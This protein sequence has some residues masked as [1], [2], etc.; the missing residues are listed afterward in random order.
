MAD[1][2]RS[3]RA[4]GIRRPPPPFRVV[5]VAKLRSLTPYLMRATF[6]GRQLD[7]LRIDE[8]AASVRLLLPSPGSDEL[9]IP[10]WTGNEFLLPD[11]SRPIIR[12]FTPVDADPG[13]RRISL[14]IVLHDG[15][16][17]SAWVTSAAPGAPAGIS[18]PA[19]GHRIDVD[20]ASYVVAGDET[21]IPAITQLI[22]AMPTGMPVRAVIEVRDPAGRIELPNHP[23]LSETWV[24][25][26][27]GDQAPGRALLDTLRSAE[28]APG[29]HVWAAGE[30]G[31]MQQIRRHLKDERRLD[32]NRMT[33]RGYWKHG[34]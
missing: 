29:T 25:V 11:G 7:D 22:Q 32:R 6:E 27:D 12:T 10:D 17:A 19:R 14:D 31:A 15:G 21:A 30:A 2:G 18:G 1:E 8:P 4:A 26:A 9:V 24:A 20:A 16:A 28:L 23:G 3:R 13:A 5:D 33:V 34:R